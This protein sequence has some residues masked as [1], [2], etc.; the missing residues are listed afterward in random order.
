MNQSAYRTGKLA[1]PALLMLSLVA[2]NSGQADPPAKQPAKP[3][4]KEAAPAADAPKAKN[5][6]GK[7]KA[8]AAASAADEAGM[9]TVTL[10]L[11]IDKGWHIYANP[12]G[13]ESMV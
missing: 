8:V 6:A 2:C 12:V 3:A 1:L 10:T 4:S 11:T 7:V 9:Q 13:N 5:S